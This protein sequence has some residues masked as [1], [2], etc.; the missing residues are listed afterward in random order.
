MKRHPQILLASII[1]LILAISINTA[2]ATERETGS[3]LS[4]KESGLGVGV[5]NRTLMGAGD[6]FEEGS[7]VYFF[8]WILGGQADEHV[9]H[10]WIQEQEERFSIDLNIGGPS[11]RTWSNKTLHPGSVGNWLVEVRDGSGRVLESMSFKCIP[12]I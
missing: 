6:T 12:S 1:S 5:E 3:H 2:K 10:V 8:T 7:K 9:T 11:W 4:I